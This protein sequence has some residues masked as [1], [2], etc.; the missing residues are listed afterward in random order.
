LQHG[1]DF[2]FEISDFSLANHWRELAVFSI[3]PEEI[4]ASIVER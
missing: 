1:V 3:G 2:G 4:P